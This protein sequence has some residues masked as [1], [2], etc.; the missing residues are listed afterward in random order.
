M[1]SGHAQFDDIW[2][3]AYIVVMIIYIGKKNNKAR[4]PFA[5]DNKKSYPTIYE[6]TLAGIAYR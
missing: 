6:K 2:P 4:F 5:L 1:K 3:E